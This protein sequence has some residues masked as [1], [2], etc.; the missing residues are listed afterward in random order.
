M[1]ATPKPLPVA[2][3]LRQSEAALRATVD[4]LTIAA[5]CDQLDHGARTS[6][7]AIAAIIASANDVLAAQRRNVECSAAVA[8]EAALEPAQDFD[9]SDYER[10]DRS[11]FRRAAGGGL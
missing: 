3:L 10:P 9:A 6:V 7:S 8:P 4:L 2:S 1:P 11:P 5:H